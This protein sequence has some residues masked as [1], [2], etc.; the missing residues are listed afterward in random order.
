M[1]T[2]EKLMLDDDEMPVEPLNR[3][4]VEWSV[5]LHPT[6]ISARRKGDLWIVQKMGAYFDTD[7]MIGKIAHVIDYHREN[8]A[9]IRVNLGLIDSSH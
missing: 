1:T 4:W 5:D 9:T 6:S 3:S 7:T 2:T 8:L